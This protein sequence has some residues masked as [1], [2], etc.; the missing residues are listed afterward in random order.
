[1]KNRE[2][3]RVLNEMA[4]IMEMKEIKWKPRAYRSAARRI[5][6]SSQDI[7]KIYRKGG[8]KGLEKIPSI[9]SGLAK[10]IADYI[11]RGKVKKWERL[12][13]GSAGR[14]RELI[15]I[16]GLGPKKVRKLHNKLGVKD[17]KSLKKAIKSKKI[18][19]ME[20][21][22]KKTEENILRSMKQYERSHERMLIGRAWT[23]A[24]EVMGY[25]K[26]NADVK[27][28]DF[29]GSLRRMKETIGD[30]DILVVTGSPEKLMDTFAGMPEVSRVLVRGKTKT[31]VVLKG[32]IQ[33]DVR[34]IERKSYG[35]A[36]QYFTGSKDH[37]INVRKLAL[38]KGYR[39]SEYG[40]FRKKGNK[41]AGGRKEEDVYGK[42]GLRWIPPEMRENN[43]EIEMAEKGKLPRLVEVKEIR[44]DLQMHTKYSDGYDTISGMAGKAKEMGYDY[45]A[46]T[47][48]SKSERIAKGMDKRK[49]K[50]QWKEFGKL[51]GSLDVRVL[52]GAEVDIL[53]DG[54]LDYG[55]DVLKELDIVL[56]AV[57]S[58]FRSGKKEMTERILKALDNRY[59]NVLAH[60]TGRMLQKR[61]GYQAD[62]DRIFEK[63]RKRGI[64]LEINCDPERLDLND[65]MITLAKKHGVKFSLGTDAHSKG[66]LENMRF[67]VGQA[68]RGW[69]RKKDVINTMTHRQ[70]KRFLEKK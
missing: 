15:N 61:E 45:I 23:I 60:P 31:S 58:G 3:A 47:D 26:E 9:G 62:F 43:G 21:F 32:G 30:I 6:N 53:D 51:S 10:H 18:R 66:S 1:M 56:V 12:R 37:N 40:L 52:K 11:E 14:L 34:A 35:A 24:W 17:I 2:I 57:H 39:L 22:G 38:R 55:D 67:G 68:R 46:I 54:S 20:G 63:C 41:T 59:V 13:K 44:G 70:L 69:L 7:E 48:H 25:L 8:K 33:V 28:I 27:K 16:G 49:I 50:K 19:G 29:A 65:R 4:D 36:L 64:A 42:L 5:E